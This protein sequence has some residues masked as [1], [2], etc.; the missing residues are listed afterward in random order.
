MISQFF[1]LSLALVLCLLGWILY[2]RRLW[3]EDYTRY[4]APSLPIQPLDVSYLN[5]INPKL[6]QNA[7]VISNSTH[8]RF[9]EDLAVSSDGTIYTGLLDG[10]VVSVRPG[11]NET[12]TVYKD[13]DS[14]MI[15]GIILTSDD[16]TLFYLSQ[17]KGL[18][19]LDIKTSEASHLLQSLNS[20]KLGALNNLCIDEANRILYITE[21]SPIRM[22][23]SNKQILLRHS[24]GR[25]I[26]FDLK[27]NTAAI[28]LENLAFP[29]GIVYEKKTNSIIFSELNRH[30]IW[31]YNLASGKKQVII[32]N[33][34]GYADNL[35]LNE[36]G[37]LLVG[38]P[39]TRDPL[40][41]PL[42]EYPQI[43]KLLLYLPQR[44]IYSLATKR[45]GGIKIDLAT[46]K[47][48]DYIFGA[49][50]KSYFLTTMLEKDGKTY[51]G[52]L[53][54]STILVLDNKNKQINGGNN[55]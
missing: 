49:P 6:F 51:F 39:A 36:K 4:S 47:I 53:R 43:R 14:G 7:T 12:T 5:H 52:S 23:F 10:S 22:T 50:T 32:K 27:T 54:S 24:L 8:L 40:L 15:L 21:S 18:I 28:V 3:D 29:N 26:S 16:S 44:L 35:K 31:R 33:I 13:S 19:K 46:G 42:N 37:Q 1:K 38:I 41:E 11:S 45:A 2:E 20:K 17:L 55:K 34:F 9:P 48:I 25:I 30:T